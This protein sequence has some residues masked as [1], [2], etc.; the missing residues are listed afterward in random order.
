MKKIM[1]KNGTL[2]SKAKVVIDNIIHEVEPAEYEGETPLSSQVLNTMQDNIEEAIEEATSELKSKIEG[3]VLYE[4]SIGTTGEV[5]LNDS[6]L[7]YKYIEIYGNYLGRYCYTKVSAINGIQTALQV[8]Q[9]STNSVYLRFSDC[10]LSDTKITRFNYSELLI[11]DP[12]YEGNVD[13]ITI[14]K[15]IGYK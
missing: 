15:V 9:R 12:V 10:F 13:I 4:D 5:T 2:I 3:T 11:G 1:F 7:N 6:I 14:Y 8:I